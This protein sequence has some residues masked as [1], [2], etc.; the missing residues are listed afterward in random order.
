M[1]TRYVALALRAG[2]VKTEISST[3]GV[4]PTSRREFGFYP[5]I[6]ATL[7]PHSSQNSL[8]ARRFILNSLTVQKPH[9]PKAES[10]QAV[11]L[12]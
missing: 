4:L 3:R 1:Q 12:L 8:T 7:G 5:R 6:H 9:R 11:K 10:A 2:A